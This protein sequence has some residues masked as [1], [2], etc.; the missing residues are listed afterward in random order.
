M[1]V[2][3][4]PMSTCT[5]KVLCTLAEKG[6]KAD[7]VLVDIMKGEG[8]VPDHLARNP[9]G[10]VPAIDDDGF[11]LFESRAII[12]YLD[13]TQP[14]AKL[15]PADPKARAVMDQWISF[16]QSHFAPPTMKIVMN[17]MF[18]PMMGKTPDQ[19][20]VEAGITEMNASLDAM[21]KQLAKT[22]FIAG[23]Q[24]TLA[25]IGFMPYLE[26]LAATPA[27]S[28]VND[29][30]AVAKWWKTISERASWKTATGKSAA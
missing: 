28:H 22:P 11:V 14:G 3:G 13:E 27:I 6:Q 20:A 4:H 19:A 8:K 26:Y 16:E 15:T 21:E 17:L 29:R 7:F 12:R 30:P 25:D 2:Y 24:F 23:Q 9:L 18:A 1:K 10:K 5:R